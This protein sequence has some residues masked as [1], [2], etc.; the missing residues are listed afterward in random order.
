MGGVGVRAY[1][2]A[3]LKRDGLRLLLDDRL[4]VHPHCR[5]GGA[6]DLL[7][8]PQ[9]VAPRQAL[10]QIVAAGLGALERVA[11]VRREVTADPVLALPVR[12]RHKLD[13]FWRAEP[14][15][16]NPGVE[17]V[18]LA[19]LALAARAVGA[20]GVPQR[21]LERR[22]AQPTAMMRLS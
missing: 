17:R 21:G 15:V 2:F 10:G 22:R 12:R 5:H 20:V 13:P 8:R 11:I 3:I 9:P 4:L 1:R 7:A 6:I 18:E 14:I 16:P 19:E